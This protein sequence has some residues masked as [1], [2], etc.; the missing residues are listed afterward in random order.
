MVQASSPRKSAQRLSRSYKRESDSETTFWSPEV[1]C[2]P[3]LGSQ[4]CDTVEV[5]GASE[6]GEWRGGEWSG[7]EG[8]GVEWSGV[9]WSGVEWSGVEWSGVEW[10]GVEWSGVEWSGVSQ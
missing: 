1:N 6:R 3:P 10:S 4:K 8:S 7:V 9:E 2:R 5:E